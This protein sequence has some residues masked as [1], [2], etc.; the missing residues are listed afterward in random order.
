MSL[1]SDLG[2]GTIYRA[3]AAQV[4]RF[5]EELMTTAETGRP[6]AK[7]KA[8]LPKTTNNEDTKSGRI[9]KYEEKCEQKVVRV[10]LKSTSRVKRAILESKVTLI[11]VSVKRIMTLFAA[12]FFKSLSKAL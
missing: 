4:E 6:S 11:A 12:F 5:Q 2:T 7:H 10:G 8:L 3:L 1:N 9:N